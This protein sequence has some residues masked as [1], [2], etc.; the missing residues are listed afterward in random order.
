[1]IKQW[2]PALVAGAL[3]GFMIVHG[4]RTYGG[5]PLLTFAVT[6]FAVGWVFESLSILTGF[7]FGNYHYTEL[8]APFL[9]HVPVSVMPAYCLMGYAAWSMA[10]ILLGTPE[11]EIERSLR[12]AGPPLAALLMVVWDVSMD[13]LRATVEQRW[14]WRG[15]GAHF[16]VPLENYLGWAFVTWIMFQAFALALPRRVPAAVA[17]EPGSVLSCRLSVPLAY[18][19]FAAEYLLNPI[20]AVR[21]DV[22]VLVNGTAMPLQRLYGNVAVLAASTMVP[23]ALLAAVLV[24]RAHVATH[25]GGRFGVRPAWDEGR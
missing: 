23:L 20:V 25:R 18:A 4:R 14:V 16:G 17:T 1:L 5:G 12:W 9:G 22:M 2:S 3:T 10:R 8:M 11:G 13:P 21:G 24:W 7:P 19:S 15:G 6:A